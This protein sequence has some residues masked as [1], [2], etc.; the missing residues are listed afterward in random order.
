MFRNSHH[1]GLQLIN[2]PSGP[3]STRK[4]EN[5]QESDENAYKRSRHESSTTKEKKKYVQ[6]A[7]TSTPTQAHVSNLSSAG[8]DPQSIHENVSAQQENLQQRRSDRKTII[9]NQNSTHFTQRTQTHHTLASFQIATQHSSSECDDSGGQ[10][11][12]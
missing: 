11:D 4:V 6:I 7:A 10:M 3:K 1:S 12:L 5:I 9:T 8:Y 2:L